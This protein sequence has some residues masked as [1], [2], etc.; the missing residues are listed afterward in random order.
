MTCNDDLDDCLAEME[1]STLKTERSETNVNDE[2]SARG[3]SCRNHLNH[4]N[5]QKDQGE[6]CVLWRG[7]PT[8]THQASSHFPP[9][10]DDFP[11]PHLH[12]ELAR[13]K[14]MEDL[15]KFLLST[16]RH[17][18]MPS[19]E[20]WVIDSKLE[21]MAKRQRIQEQNEVRA[22]F[23]SL[24]RPKEDGWRRRM[25]RKRHQVDSSLEKH[26]T[27]SGLRP[28]VH[29]D[30]VMPSM[31]DVEDDASKRLILEIEHVSRTKGDGLDAN[32]I[33]KELCE[34]SCH[35]AKRLQ[36]LEHRLGSVSASHY[37]TK[38]NGRIHLEVERKGEDPKIKL[39][40]GA[41]AGNSSTTFF[42]LVF[43]RKPRTDG[44]KVK[45]FVIKIN[46]LHYEKLRQ[47]F[48]SIH[49]RIDSS[50]ALH[51][52]SPMTLGSNRLGYSSA[53]HIFHHLVF[54]LELRYASLAGGQQLHDLRG[55]GMQGAI[56]S[57]V[58]DCISKYDGNSGPQDIIECFASPFN[59]Y[60][61]S[62][63]SLFH[64]DLDWHFGSCGDFFSVPIDFF[65]TGG[66]NEANPPFSP[67]LMQRM[68]Q[69]MEEHLEYAD[70]IKD[71][72]MQSN[73]TFVI[74]VPTCHSAQNT[75]KNIVQEFAWKSY[76]A[77]IKS[78]YLSKYFVLKSREHGYIEGSQHL[79]P[80]RFKESSYD[81]SIIILQSRAARELEEKSPKFTSRGFEDDLRLAFASRHQLELN[82]RRHV[83]SEQGD[84]IKTDISVVRHA[85][86]SRNE[87]KH[88]KKK[89]K[90]KTKDP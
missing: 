76:Q 23:D 82:E 87:V 75:D 39:T 84:D 7:P 54:C 29:Y 62:Y 32:A 30:P 44:K 11:L 28:Q 25:K 41:E 21:E 38:G 46:S 37:Y 10:H 49:N 71:D 80:T 48:H 72:E 74:V 70:S 79:R 67:G 73:L 61:S 47:M 90:K 50:H 8:T 65:R 2:D 89:S 6:K 1:Q 22:S 78:R 18:R 63:F 16:C 56:H 83:E 55:G 36:N 59:V 42:S 9:I 45:P 31:A 3:K 15:S 20:R 60:N 17:L 43:S 58:F 5:L 66:V 40:N 19:F 51:V 68:I 24:A 27:S 69:R 77:M 86:A 53:T 81:T 52:P 35:A 26:L 34:Q 14:H 88:R 33:C 13:H 4:G 12:V 64:R 57:Q 85:S